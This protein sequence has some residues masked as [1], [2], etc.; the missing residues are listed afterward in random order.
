[1]VS[2][3][4]LRP[5]RLEQLARERDKLLEPE[6]L[7]AKLGTELSNFVRLRIVQIIVARHDR[8]RGRRQTW[9]S[10]DGAQELE[11]ARQWHSQVQNHR[12][13]P[14]SLGQAQPFIG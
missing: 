11:A 13:G 4:L 6:R 1:H 10:S 14:M 2:A 12:M 5:I 9:N 7:V 3:K 8:D